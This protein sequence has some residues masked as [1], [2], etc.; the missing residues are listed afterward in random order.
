MFLGS[1]EPVQLLSRVGWRVTLLSRY[2]DVLLSI[3]VHKPST[4]FIHFPTLTCDISRLRSLITHHWILN[5][6]FFLCHFTYNSWAKFWCQLC[7]I[8]RLKWRVISEKI[9]FGL[10][11][12]C[13]YISFYS[14]LV[15]G[16]IWAGEVG[17]ISRLFVRC[18]EIIDRDM[19]DIAINRT[20]KVII[21]FHWKRI[22]SNHF[23]LNP[24]ILLFDR[25]R[26]AFKYG[27]E[28]FH[29]IRFF[30][31]GLLEPCH[32]C[33]HLHRRI[34]ILFTSN[35]SNLSPLYSFLLCFCWLFLWDL[36][37]FRIEISIFKN[38]FILG[39]TFIPVWW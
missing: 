21:L 2:H 24:I 7:I 23:F 32:S 30:I 31:S 11:F 19:N 5:L 26:L 9:L 8:R 14:L 4:D 10:I 16:W 17:F 1:L 33:W 6:L 22:R 3:S 34:K 38:H 39:F 29:F 25:I 20:N 18:N 15:V 36:H 37:Y 35:N 12:S 28:S 27:L 13:S